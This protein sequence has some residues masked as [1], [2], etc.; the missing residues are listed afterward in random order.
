MRKTKIGVIGGSGIYDIDGIENPK[1]QKVESPWGIP[2]DWIFTGT[3][4]GVEIAFLPRH[5]RGHTLSP[6]DI[7]Y[8]ANIDALKRLGV[9]DLI[10]I[11]ACGSFRDNMKPGHFVV[12]NQF[13]DRTTARENSFFGTGCVAHVSIANPTC[14]RLSE[15]CL[16]TAKNQGITVHFGGTYLAMEGPQFST[17]AESKLYREVWG[18]DVIG[19]T[20]M[21]EAKLAREAELCYTS[22]AMITDYD[23]WHPDHGEVDVTEIIKILTENST[24]AKGLIANLTDGLRPERSQCTQGCD[25]ALNFAIM[26]A[27][28]ARDPVL[29]AKLDAVAGR[30][31]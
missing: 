16:N 7:P 9:T 26:T 17:L 27:P 20:N 4:H 13:I 25:T 18:C 10:S 28:E 1:W 5:G 31:L 22:I 21:P 11:S 6:S 2:S 23:S 24:K 15:A 19:M 30:V 8:R 14:H 12:V 29:I 3:L